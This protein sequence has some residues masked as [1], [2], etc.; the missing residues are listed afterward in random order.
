MK[1]RDLLQEAPFTAAQEEKFLKQ[2]KSAQKSEFGNEFPDKW[3]IA[4]LI[5]KIEPRA[6]R[7]GRGSFGFVYGKPRG[8]S[9]VKVSHGDPKAIRYLKWCLDHQDNPHVPKI[10]SLYTSKNSLYVRMEPLSDITPSF[11]WSKEHLPLLMWIHLNI[12]GVPLSI[13]ESILGGV[14]RNA[15]EFKEKKKDFNPFGTSAQHK[16]ALKDLFS[17]DEEFNAWLKKIKATW[18]DDQA[19]KVLKAAAKINGGSRFVDVLVDKHGAA[20]MMVRP[21]TSTIVISDP[22]C[23]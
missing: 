11:K 1:V 20:N 3:E 2:L 12:E 8:K 6:T 9:V 16:S 18:T 23:S 10:Y 5:K 15:K 19:V 21:G 17:S 4:K 14:K 22:V 13:F 7:L